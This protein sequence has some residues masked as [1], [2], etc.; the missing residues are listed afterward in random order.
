MEQEG[1]EGWVIHPGE[2]VPELVS[3]TFFQPCS[4]HART[5]SRSE[6]LNYFNLRKLVPQCS[7]CSSSP[8]DRLVQARPFVLS[9]SSQSGKEQH[10]VITKEC[11]LSVK[12]SVS[13]KL[14]SRSAALH[15]TTPS[16]LL[17]LSVCSTSPTCKCT[18]LTATMSFS[19]VAVFAGPTRATPPAALASPFPP[20]HHPSLLAIASCAI[21]FCSTPQLDTAASSARWTPT[22]PMP[23]VFLT[24]A[25]RKLT[26]AVSSPT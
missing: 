20:P 8:S 22:A 23:S 6:R 15:T 1:G 21:A 16:A 17:R 18:P 5:G 25:S 24:A 13:I 11:K 12:L 26:N 7:R 9:V 3:A 2:W 10:S 4:Q 19:S 14:P